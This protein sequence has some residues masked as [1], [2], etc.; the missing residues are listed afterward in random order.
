MWE[1]L[2]LQLQAAKDQ[3]AAS[4]GLDKPAPRRTRSFKVI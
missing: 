3:A 4:I 2:A 1:K